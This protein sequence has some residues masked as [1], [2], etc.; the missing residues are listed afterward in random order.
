MSLPQKKE[1]KIVDVT[2][3]TTTQIETAFNNNFGNIGWRI[4]EIKDI[5]TS[6][7]IVLER[8]I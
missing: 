1:I 4:I 2:G 8:D 3:N 7:F 5:G 6:R